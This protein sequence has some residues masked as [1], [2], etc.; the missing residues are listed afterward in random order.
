MKRIKLTLMALLA[1]LGLQAAN[2]VEET[3]QVTGGV[4]LTADVDYIITG[5]TPFATAGSVDI[6]N[7]DHAVLIFKNI[8]PS[9]VI[10]NH[11]KNVYING[12]A[13]KNGTNCQVKMYAQGAIVLPYGNNC[14]PLVCYTQENFQ[15]ESYNSYGMGHTGGYM[16]TMSAAQLNNNIRSFKLKRGYMVTFAVGVSGWGYSR[17]FIADQADLEIASVPAPLNG[18]IS[19][20]RIF[21]W[22]N[23]QKKGL[24]SDT[25]LEANQ[26]LNSSWCYDW[27]TGW[28]MGP[29]IECVPNH[30]Y[31]DWPSSSACGSVTYSC[32]MKTNNEPGNS[33]DDR[34]QDVATVLDN[35]QNLMRTGMRL[36]SESSHDGSMGHLKEFMDSIDARGWRCDI[37]DLHCYWRSDQFNSGNLN[38]YSDEYGHGRPIWISEWIWGASWNNNGIFAACSDRNNFWSTENQNANYNGVKPILDVL[39]A[40]P[41]VERY[42]YWNSEADCSKIY[43]N[44]SLSKLGKYY[45]EMESGLGYNPAYEFVPKIVYKNP[46]ELLLEYTKKSNI[47][48]LSWS[49]SN[50]DMIDSI[51]VE[52]RAPGSYQ[53]EKLTNITP[54]DMNGKQAHNYSYEHQ[55]E[56]IGVHYYRVT[57]YYDNKKK[58][59]TNETT[60]TIA[61]AKNVGSLQYGQLTV[62]ST[63]AVTT[64]IEP[65]EEAPYVVAGLVSNRNTG[66][67][68]TT[69]IRNMNKTS[70]SFRLYPWQ[71]DAPVDFKRSESIDYLMLPPDTIFH[72]DNDMMLI[73]QKIGSVRGSEVEVTFPQAFPEGVIP[74][75]V[76]QQNTSVSSYAPVT[77]RVYDVTNTGFKVI[78]TRQEEAAGSFNGQNVN[79][80]ACS[81]GQVP[82]GEGKLLTVGRNDT[83]AVGRTT[84]RLVT[85]FDQQGDTQFLQDPYIIAAPQ[86]RNYAKTTVFRQNSVETDDRGVCGI[87]V[88]RQDD[89]TSTDKTASSVD[90]GDF[91]GWFIIS[92]DPNGT[93]NE[94]PVIVPTAIGQVKPVDMGYCI[95]QRVITANNPS[96]RAYN[97][98]GQ[99]VMLGTK[100]PAGVYFITDGSQTRKVVLK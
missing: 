74:V 1:A 9:K 43:L 18:K 66:N 85:L 42:A 56:G 5:T 28:D 23:A 58:M 86:T 7:T 78:L 21:K 65:Q 47:A 67:G 57:E 98:S 59:S 4:S 14:K 34:P 71:L 84:A 6:V 100:L 41:R 25:R 91:M 27:A 69:Q 63:D 2:T 70:F 10:S 35:W 55:P 32:H 16:N 99:Q 19:S 24:A 39:N 15:G 37:L 93:G 26:A 38:W 87:R 36:C 49:D 48:S 53:W 61:A 88:R 52:H 81:P 73:S 95:S 44:G 17:C 79:Y 60:V 92:T 83:D 89:P 94:Q 68:I 12:E 3:T 11:L 31:E 20:Y 54:K 96:L 46:S 22:Q 64:D 30:I 90:N 51:L 29:D 77:V 50:G 33:A 45:A 82:I 72:L 40:N 97:T 76:A 62:A 80:F 75:V 8:K 13:A